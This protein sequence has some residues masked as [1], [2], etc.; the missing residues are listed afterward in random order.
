VASKREALI[1]SA[2]KSL[3]KGKVDAALKD[4]LKVLEEAPGDINVLNKVGDLNVRLGRNEDSIPYFLRIAEHYGHDGFYVRAIAMYKKINKLDPAR[5]DIYEKLAELYVKQQLWMEA[6]SNY[7]VLADYLLKQDNLQGAIGI[8]QKMVSIEPQN[9]Q[10][11]VKLADLF[12]QGKRIPE[13][14][15]EYAVVAAALSER[16]A[17]EEAIRVY[18]KALKLAPDNL[19]ILKTL[20][21]LLLS[22][23]AID[24]A[25]AALRKGL[26]ASP[27]SVPLFLL[28]AE[29]ALTAN[30]MAEARSY[31]SKAQAVD[32]ENEEVLAAVVRIQI[33]GR[34][35]DLAWAAASPLAD[36]SLRRGEAKKALAIL[37]PIAKAAPDAD[38]LVKKIVDIAAGSG[39]EVT[40]LPYRSAL[41]ELYRKKGRLAEAADLLR[42]C[43]RIQPD[44]AEFRSR[45]SQLEP[46]AGPAVVSP[47]R[48]PPTS[49]E[50]NLEVT[51][52]GFE[53]PHSAKHAPPPAPPPEPPPPVVA[54]TT[55]SQEFEFDLVDEDLEEVSGEV[56]LEAEAPPPTPPRGLPAP[57]AIADVSADAGEPVWGNLSAAE[58]LEAYEARQAELARRA[59]GEEAPA[60]EDVE[61]LRP[62][63]EL[64]PAVSF[65]SAPTSFDLDLAAP[66]GFGADSGRQ[67]VAFPAPSGFPEPVQAEG[68]WRASTFPESDLLPGVE[69]GGP[70]SYPAVVR[71][72]SAD[73]AF[74]DALVEAD[75]FRRYGLV[76]KAIDQLRPWLE[77]APGNLKVREKLF[78]ILLEQGSREEALEQAWILADAYADSGRE[79]RIR[80]LEALLGEPLRKAEIE[81]AVP[82]EAPVPEEAIPSEFDLSF[83]APAVAPAALEEP[84]TEIISSYLESRMQGGLPTADF[85][86][87]E[88]EPGFGISLEEVSAGEEG[89]LEEEIVLEEAV[90]LEEAGPRE[91]GPREDG[92][93]AEAAALAEATAPPE[94]PVSLETPTEPEPPPAP[95]PARAALP[96]PE[97]FEA[98]TPPEP[99]RRP[100]PHPKLSPEELLGLAKPGAAQ[101]PRKVKAVRPE[102]VELELLG[103]RPSKLKG[104]AKGAPKPEPALPDD[105]LKSLRTP[106]HAPAP[107]PKSIVEPAPVQEIPIAEAVLPV[108]G[109]PSGEAAPFDRF[110]EP[111]SPPSEQHLRFPVAVPLQPTPEELAEL[112]FCL[113]Q[114]M[115]VDAAERLQSLEGRFPA[116]LELEARRLRL[117]GGRGGAEAPRTALHDIL[118]DDLDSVLDASLG[119]ALSEDM[120]RESTGPSLAIPPA[121]EGA[122]VIDD[123][124]LF[125]DE[126]EFFNFADE[127]HTELK[128]EA[129][130]VPGEDGREVSLE[131][132]FRD[133]KKGVEQ[134]LSPEDYETHYNLGI[135]YKE[136][137]LTDEAIGEFQLAAKDPLHAVECCSMLG[138]CFLE[139]GLPQLSV[140]WYRKGLETIGVKDDDRLGLLYALAGVLEQIGDRDGAYR[141]YLDIYGTNAGYRDVPERLKELKPFATS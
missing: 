61:E 118:S 86:V 3:Q 111:G 121:Q 95:R 84:Q 94:E 6:K 29:A 97:A 23:N 76:E 104:K 122:P 102:D 91:D 141:T 43:S 7:Q 88:V 113:D 77:K 70:L 24:Q 71:A 54:A 28:A 49:L 108:P 135:A 92:A 19:D 125:S 87:V 67:H 35:P 132:I 12:T 107:V 81:E 14:L 139:K 93:T 30:D 115:V 124:G 48:I 9:L 11:H 128:R 27:R 46:Q 140:K 98:I 101:A 131:E 20:V 138:L 80:G 72:V 133:F 75:V 8:Y 44:N 117:E 89:P 79:D 83:E 99:S 114:G 4:Y 126:Q 69:S 37:V 55:G 25:R 53:V 120:V 112:D 66:E 110:L 127:L 65:P 134:Q 62:E 31:A 68:R 16:G 106:A 57:A 64:P 13:A 85:P 90:L 34:R 96:Q 56:P 40:A 103:A 59:F 50:R 1:S 63:A 33:K 109:E 136:M 18:E 2:E 82:T 42:I 60:V 73:A 22:I 58:A 119:R 74:E 36:A 47:P 21:P 105:L 100:G 116:D 38:E 5:L 52:S 51:V 78:E 45:L 123:S 137:G 32:P 130:P 41:A 129:E 15:R 10:L 17:N 39:D 26:D